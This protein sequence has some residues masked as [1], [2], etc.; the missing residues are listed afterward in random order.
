MNVRQ[1]K[2]VRKYHKRLNYRKETI[3]KAFRMWWRM[4]R[5]HLRNAARWA[6]ITDGAGNIAARRVLISTDTGYDEEGVPV[7]LIT[8]S[9]GIVQCIDGFPQVLCNTDV[10]VGIVGIP[11]EHLRAF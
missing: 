7:S 2:K 8:G 5:K 10:G 9:M 11:A 6:G 3:R 4:R 1:A